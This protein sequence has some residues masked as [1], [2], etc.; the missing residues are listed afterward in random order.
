V[1]DESR[2]FATLAAVA[3]SSPLLNGVHD[4]PLFE[5]FYTPF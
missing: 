4:A 3:W 5:D 2:L 1:P